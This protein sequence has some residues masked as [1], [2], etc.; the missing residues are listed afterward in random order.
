MEMSETFLI[1]YSLT[2]YNNE[3]AIS[4]YPIMAQGSH[5]PGSCPRTLHKA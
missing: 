4:L 2:G 5:C 1:A 3:Q